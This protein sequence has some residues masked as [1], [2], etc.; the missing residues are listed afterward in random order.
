MGAG[1]KMANTILQNKVEGVD[2]GMPIRQCLDDVKE[3]TGRS[4][5]EMWRAQRIV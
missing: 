4:L 5:N 1:L 3:S 2:H